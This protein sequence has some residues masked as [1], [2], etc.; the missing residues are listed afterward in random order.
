MRTAMLMVSP[1]TIPRAIAI[2]TLAVRVTNN[3]TTKTIA[4]TATTP[5]IVTM[6][7]MTNEMK[8][9]IGAIRMMKMLTIKESLY[10]VSRLSS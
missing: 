4:T 5:K 7:K 2:T 3:A 9:T 8:T 10:C 6:M 1:E